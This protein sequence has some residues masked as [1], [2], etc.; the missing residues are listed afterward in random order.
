MSKNILL[1][2]SP[3]D[4]SESHL[5]HALAASYVAWR[6]RVWS[7]VAGNKNPY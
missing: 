4:A 3:P 5:C 6:R 1:I 2:Q 7:W